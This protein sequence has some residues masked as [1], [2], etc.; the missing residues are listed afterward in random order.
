V[1]ESIY[2]DSSL[3]R[4]S[5]R[6]IGALDK[7]YT[8]YLCSA[9]SMGEAKGLGLTFAT[10]RGLIIRDS[11]SLF[12]NLNASM[13]NLVYRVNTA[14]SMACLDGH[15]PFSALFRQLCHSLVCSPH[16]SLC[17]DSKRDVKQPFTAQFHKI[18]EI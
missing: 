8:F 6:H 4:S 17:S 9:T 1:G 18:S 7:L 14:V 5:R 15:H 2:V 3:G 12:E 16:K 11:S 10:L 13:N